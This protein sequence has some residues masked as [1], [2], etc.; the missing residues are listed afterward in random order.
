[1][2][3]IDLDFENK[4][5]LQA[6]LSQLKQELTLQESPSYDPAI[7]SVETFAKLPPAH[8]QQI[9]SNISTY[10]Q[11][12]S[13]DIEPMIEP[14]VERSPRIREIA[15]L[16]CALNQFGLR[17]ASDNVFDVISLDDVIELYN[18]QGVQLYRNMKFFKVCSY[19]LLDLSVHSWE[20]LYDKPSSVVDATLKVI[21]RLFASE[22]QVVPYS[23]DT[24]LQKEKSDFVKSLKTLEVT[25]RYIV[26]LYDIQTG[27]PGGAFSTYSA[28]IIAEGDQSSRFRTI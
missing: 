5:A 13:Q 21:E 4:A 22:G 10:L 19:N 26:P 25:P 15:R 1:M 16:K 8:Q 28:E 7:A 11:I 12:L 17:A 2:Y 3:A 23:I 14:G 20:K 27:Q 6:N 9:L 24:Y 18:I